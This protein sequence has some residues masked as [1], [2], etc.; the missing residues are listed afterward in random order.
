MWEPHAVLPTVP[1]VAHVADVIR[2]GGRSRRVATT[3][4]ITVI[5]ILTQ[6]ILLVRRADKAL[7]NRLTNR[8]ILRRAVAFR[9][10]HSRRQ[11][12]VDAVVQILLLNV[13]QSGH[14][15]GEVFR[16]AGRDLPSAI[17]VERHR[18]V[19]FVGVVVD[20]Q[21]DLLEVVVAARPTSRFTRGLHGGQQQGD[22][23][24]D[25]RDNDKQLHEREATSVATCG[26]WERHGKTPKNQ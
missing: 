26:N 6:R 21:A 24:A 8:Q 2:A 22:E 25:D 12:K 4:V 9:P 17:V 5:L 18:L 3:N 7:E 15:P 1:H 11:A 19:V 10:D 13:R 20:R 23:H 14:D 16:E